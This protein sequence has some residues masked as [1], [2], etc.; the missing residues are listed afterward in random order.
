MRPAVS[1]IVPFLG[2]EAQGRELVA[3]L[4]A[5]APRPDDEMIVADNSPEPAVRPGAGS[6]VRVVAA[7]ER[8]SAAHA[9]NVAAA[10]AANDWLLFLDSDC[11]LPPR[12]LDRYF[13]PPPGDRC[14]IVA[15]EISGDPA[16]PGT[17]ARW[18]RSR[19]GMWVAE[20]RTAGLRSAGVTAN[21]LVRGEAFAAAGGFRLGGGADFDLSWRLQ[22][23]GWQLE[24]RPEAL[25]HHRDRERLGELGQQ[26]RA[27]G[28]DRVNLRRTYPEVPRPRLAPAGRSF[29]AA[30]AWLVR[31]Q[32]ERA[33]FS[34]LD[35]FYFANAWLG[36]RL[37]G[38]RHRSAD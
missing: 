16:Q 6:A 10:T 3:R 15:G 31:G 14:A 37:G 1:V 38:P 8:R 25:V 27:Y 13:E 4:E 35:G 19:R 22:D 12:L 28:A 21:M 24:Y 18:A 17:L 32:R 30:A 20:L 9:R 36:A 11:V 34:L 26:A 23:A 5:L 2:D 7:R 33:R 29:A